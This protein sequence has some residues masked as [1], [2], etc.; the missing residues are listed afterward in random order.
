M[1]LTGR[2]YYDAPSCDKLVVATES[3]EH[4]LTRFSPSCVIKIPLLNVPQF[5]K[6][7]IANGYLVR[8]IAAMNYGQIWNLHITYILDDKSDTWYGMSNKAPG[9]TQRISIASPFTFSEADKVAVKDRFYFD[10][11]AETILS[12]LNRSGILISRK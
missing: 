11:T 9:E 5:M 10:G 2:L 6:K 8:R 1:K 3:I 7:R 4:I 12:R